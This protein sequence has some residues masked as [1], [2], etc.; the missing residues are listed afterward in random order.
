MAIERVG[1]ELVGRKGAF[2]LQHAGILN[3]GEGTLTVQ[4]I[5]DSGPGDL[6]GLTGELKIIIPRGVAS[7]YE[8]TYEIAVQADPDRLRSVTNRP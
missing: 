5:P 8:F 2:Y 4:V 1:G 6:V 3:R 7:S